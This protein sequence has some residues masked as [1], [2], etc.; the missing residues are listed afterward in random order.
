MASIVEPQYGVQ[1]VGWLPDLKARYFVA[2]TERKLTHP[3]TIL[4]VETAKRGLLFQ[5]A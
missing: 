3:A 2:T 5:D 4:V 1:F